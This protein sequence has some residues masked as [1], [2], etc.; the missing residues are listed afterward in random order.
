M[1]ILHTSDWHL[2][3]TFFGVDQ[4]ANQSRFLDFLVDT[5]TDRQVDAVLV[6][7][8]VYDRAIPNPEAMELF[9]DA[10]GRLL[11]AGVRLVVSSGNHDSFVR[12]GVG[13]RQ[14]DS[15]GLH[16]RTRLSDI[17]WPVP[18]PSAELPEIVVYGIPYLEPGLVHSR[19]GVERTHTAVLGWAMEQVRHHAGTHFPGLPLVVMA[20]AFVG[21]GEG[22]E[23]ERDI[24]IGGVGIAPA[25]VF[26]GTA[27]TALGHLHKPQAITPT[28]RYSGSPVPYSFSEATVD[29]MMF[30]VDFLGAVPVVD[31]I[32]I[33]RFTRVET[34]RGPIADVLARAV[35]YADAL[36]AVE[37]TDEQRTENALGKLKEAYPGLLRLTY[38]NAPSL[39][40]IRQSTPAQLAART[41]SEVFTEFIADVTGRPAEPGQVAR[42]ES[43][44]AAARRENA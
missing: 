34:V 11:A 18:L 9:D 33:P 31:T 22:S 12:L 35:D 7:G 30:L 5:A 14:F 19:F 37:L 4:H 39:G 10:V 23:S 6:S 17:T 40:P 2:G 41:D 3:R 29:K 24:G 38:S 1:R 8:D 13:R 26:A 15:V 28:V 21:G 43:A 44:L 32:A 27:Y 42:F 25:S 36:T 20:H 16:I